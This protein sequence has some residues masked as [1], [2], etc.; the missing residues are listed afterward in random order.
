M[1]VTSCRSV[2]L[3]RELIADRID[4]IANTRQ[5][6]EILAVA[7]GHLREAELSEALRAGKVARFVATDQDDASLDVVRQYRHEIN[8]C[9]EPRRLTVKDFIAKKHKLG[10][11]DLI[12]AAGLYD[13]L[14]AKTASRLTKRLFEL[15]KPGGRILV[16]NFLEGLW[17]LPY[18]EALSLSETQSG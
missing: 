8:G 7:C 10:Q 4:E 5:H 17:E 11:F 14:D 13:Y 18:M 12:Y 1:N 15:L 2:A 3:R 16:G 9:I 6:I